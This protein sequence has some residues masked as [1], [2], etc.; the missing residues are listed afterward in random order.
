[1]QFGRRFER[2]TGQIEQL[3]LKLEDLEIRREVEA[4]PRKLRLV[5]LPPIR[6]SEVESHYPNNFPVKCKR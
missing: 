6:A 4:P 5:S 1:M 2:L 3:E